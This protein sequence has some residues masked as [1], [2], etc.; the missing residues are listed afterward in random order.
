MEQRRK[1]QQAGHGGQHHRSQYRLRQTFQQPGEKQQAQRECNGGEYESERRAGTGP[2]VHRGLREATG[3]RI[4][5]SE[6]RQQIGCADAEK[7]LPR[8]Q[9]V[10]VLCGKGTG[11]RDA[12]DIREQQASRGQ[13]NNALD[14]SVSQSDGTFSSGRPAGIVPV[15]GTPKARSPNTDAATIDSATTQSATGFPGSQR[16]PSMSSTIA[17]T[18]TATTT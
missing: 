6:R 15:V 13:W 14:I 3:H 17:M 12:L 10:S 4:T 11:G 9:G 5:L 18:P 1:I 2:V 16:S 8:V 7:L